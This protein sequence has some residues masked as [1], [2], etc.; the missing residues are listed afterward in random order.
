MKSQLLFL[1]FFLTGNVT[2]AQANNDA[3]VNKRAGAGNTYAV[4]VGISKYESSG[5]PQLEYAHK[6]ALFFADYLKSKSGGSVPEE[7]IRLLVNENATYSAIYDALD[8]LLTTCHKDDLVYFYFSGHG[9]M[10]NTTIYNLGF[11]LSYNTPRTN[12][13]NNAV[14]IED[15]NNIANTLSVKINAKV[16][17]ITDAC[18]SGKLAGT[19]YRGTF[20]VGDQL[21]TVQN[22]EIRITSCAPD[23][24]SAED[25]GWGGGRGVFSYYLVNGLEGLA[26]EDQNK[27]VTVSEI[28]N[29]LDSS[30]SADVLLAQKAIKQIPVIKGNNGFTLAM[31]DNASLASLMKKPAPMVASQGMG[32]LMM[33]VLKSFSA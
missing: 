2:F 18:H 30:L 20:L 14:R 13:I 3:A 16:V 1:V 24:L 27:I 4:V 10:E 11:L 19:D 21:R 31:V 17:L 26:D 5:I 23:Q 32:L 8:W 28:K 29:Y 22:K 7:N 33:G 15:L 9:D 25:E 6:D 12:Y